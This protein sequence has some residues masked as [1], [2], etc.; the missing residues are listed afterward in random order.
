MDNNFNNEN[1]NNP[2]ENNGDINN[3]P[4]NM[5]TVNDVNTD[6]IDPQNI[7]GVTDS[8]LTNDYT[9]DVNSFDDYLKEDIDEITEKIQEDYERGDLSSSQYDNLMSLVQ[10]IEV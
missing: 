4:N 10:D 1:I 7:F 3:N 6:E 2:V 9:D 8:S 5:V